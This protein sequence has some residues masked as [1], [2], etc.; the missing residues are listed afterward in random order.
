MKSFIL[1][2][3]VMGATVFGCA[4]KAPQ[5]IVNNPTPSK[6]VSVSIEK[7]NSAVEKIENANHDIISTTTLLENSINTNEPKKEDLINGI[8][9]I[10]D[11]STKIQTSTDTLKEESKTL[12]ALVA[13]VKNLESQVIKLQADLQKAKQDMEKVRQDAI[14]NIYSSLNYFFALGFLVILAGG[15]VGFMV[16]PRLGML[17]AGI[18]LLGIGLA[19][20]AI[21]YLK[22][23]AV[24]G[25][26]IIIG[27]ILLTL[28]LV[29]HHLFV[30]NRANTENVQLIEKIKDELK[31]DQKETIFG[32]PT[33]KEPVPLYQE[34]QS[35]KTQKIVK[36]I[37]EKIKK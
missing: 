10:K 22:T 36:Q 25:I 18:G 24:V 2:L 12:S 32:P 28:Y 30:T 21:F 37:R 6:D 23:I 3:F 13:Q 35:P 20:G 26:A 1:S 19:A 5:S 15:V 8:N 17:I 16:N 9:V 11:N 29:I 7:Q 14:K 33:E 31:P 27:S 34:I 4:S